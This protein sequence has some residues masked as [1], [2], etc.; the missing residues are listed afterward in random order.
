ME[1]ENESTPFPGSPPDGDAL[2]L[3][4]RVFALLACGFYLEQARGLAQA[5]LAVLAG[6]SASG[7]LHLLMDSMTPTGIPLRTPFGPRRSLNLYKTGSPG[8]W[9]CLLAFCAAAGGLAMWADRGQ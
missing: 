4:L 3:G 8:E 2:A 1:P 7:L 9:L 6:F 5:A